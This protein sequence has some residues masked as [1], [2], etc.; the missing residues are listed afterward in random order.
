MEAFIENMILCKAD[1]KGQNGTMV[2]TVKINVLGSCI[3]RVLLLDGIQTKPGT[4]NDNLELDYFLDKQ[5]IVCAMTPS[6]FTKEAIDTISANELYD[7]SRIR[8]LK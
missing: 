4:A 7:K 3:S 6:T 1:R 2:G 8:S 5:N